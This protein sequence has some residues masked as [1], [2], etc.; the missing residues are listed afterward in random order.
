MEWNFK[1]VQSLLCEFSG[2]SDFDIQQD[3][4]LDDLRID[5]YDFTDFLLE[6]R[7]EIESKYGVEM[8][9]ENELR[10][11]IDVYR[12]TRDLIYIIA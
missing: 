11:K 7:Q 5:V 4:S 2:L 10:S 6:K 8:V 12:S 1:A 9:D 3:N